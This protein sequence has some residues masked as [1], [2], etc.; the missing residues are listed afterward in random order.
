MPARAAAA[1]AS[2]TYT[3]KPP[4]ISNTVMCECIVYIVTCSSYTSS[5]DAGGARIVGRVTRSAYHTAPAGVRTAGAQGCRRSTVH[6]WSQ[7]PPP[8][9]VR[10]TPTQ[11]PHLYTRCVAVVAVG[12]AAVGGRPE[13]LIRIICLPFVMYTIMKFRPV[14]FLGSWWQRW[15]NQPPLESIKITIKRML[16]FIRDL[17]F[18]AA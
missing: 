4:C 11:S 3:R 12:G 9:P 5:T 13:T 18:R 15:A 2:T 10:W 16:I 17:P 6:C 1:A 8:P 14:T 7:P